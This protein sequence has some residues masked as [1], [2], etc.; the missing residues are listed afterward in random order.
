MWREPDVPPPCAAARPDY[1]GSLASAR[2]KVAYVTRRT[3]LRPNEL[4]QVSV[5]SGT[6]TTVRIFLEKLL[7]GVDGDGVEQEATM[8]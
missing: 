2:E 5:G 4:P 6:R 3:P 7:N 8:P 1:R